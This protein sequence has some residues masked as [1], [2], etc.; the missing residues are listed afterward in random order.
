MSIWRVKWHGDWDATGYAALFTSLATGFVLALVWFLW[1]R[2]W[3]VA[4][5]LVPDDANYSRWPHIRSVDLQVVG[6]SMVG[7]FS[8]VDGIRYFTRSVGVYLGI[9]YSE[10]LGDS[11][12]TFLDWLI[13]E[14]T[15]ASLATIA[16]G[17]WLVLGSRGIVRLIRRLRRP[18]LY[19]RPEV[20]R[21][22][23]ELPAVDS[24]SE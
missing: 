22:K 5:K 18:E 7:L 12:V 13:M 6:F 24:P 15:L 4:E 10:N 23:Q 11:T 20:S 14:D 3:W 1:T 2:A 19:E 17:L 8:L 21:E 9:L 16:V